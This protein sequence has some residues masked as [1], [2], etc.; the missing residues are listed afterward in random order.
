[1][2]VYKIR[3][4]LSPLE[5]RHMGPDYLLHVRREM[6]Y[7]LATEMLE[8]FGDVPIKRNHETGEQYLEFTLNSWEDYE[9]DRAVQKASDKG[10]TEGYIRGAGDERERCLKRISE[11]EAQIAMKEKAPDQ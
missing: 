3:K 7:D 5:M 9:V 6:V 4:I 1:M 8:V 11:L 10:R 2:A